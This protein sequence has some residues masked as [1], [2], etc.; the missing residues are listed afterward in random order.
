MG[1]IAYDKSGYI[2]VH[3]IARLTVLRTCLARTRV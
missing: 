2:T 1:F 3:R